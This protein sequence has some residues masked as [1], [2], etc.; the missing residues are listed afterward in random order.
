VPANVEV[1]VRVGRFEPLR[2]RLRAMGARRVALLRQRDTYFR[3]PG[4]RLKLREEGGAAMLIPYRRPD[5]AGDRRSDYVVIPVRDG[6]RA[7]RHLRSA[8]GVR[9]VVDKVRELWRIDHTRVHL[10]RVR[11]LGRFLELETES[12]ASARAECRRVL[13][14]LGLHRERAIAGSYGELA[15]AR[16]R[17]PL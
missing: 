17:P 2:A 11:G 12:H 10:D 7:R 3:V 5:R 1:K 15:S 13:E 9:S 8:L 14:G 6:A 16:R 4:L